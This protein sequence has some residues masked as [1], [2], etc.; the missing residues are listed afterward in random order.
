GLPAT[1]VFYGLELVLS[2]P[3]F[4][5]TAVYFV[6][7]VDMSPLQLV[8]VGTVMVVAVFLFEVPTGAI[9]DTYGRRL[10]L[11]IAFGVQGAAVVVVCSVPSFSVHAV[12]WIE[13]GRERRL[14]RSSDQR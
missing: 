12:S 14:E 2:M 9:A 5:V 3:S 4:I 11:V 8:L 13:G 7:E 6:R 10:S 1:R